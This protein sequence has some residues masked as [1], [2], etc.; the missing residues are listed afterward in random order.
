MGGEC[1]A[2][3]LAGKAIAQENVEAGKSG[4]APGLHIFLE[5]DDTGQPHFYPWRAN[6]PLIV[7]DDIDPVEKYSFYRFLPR[8]QR[9]REVT[10]RPEVRIQHQGRTMIGWW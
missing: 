2:T 10:E 1:F 6:R 3:V 8:P 4:S 7:R 9:Q 5:R